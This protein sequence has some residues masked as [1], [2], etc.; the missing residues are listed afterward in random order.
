MPAIQRFM[1]IVDGYFLSAFEEQIVAQGKQNDVVVLTGYNTG[2]VG[3]SMLGPQEPLT[4]QS[5]AKQAREQYGDMAVEFLKLYPAATDQ[6][7]EIAKAQS[8]RDR[9]LTSM[10]L[11]A[12]SRAK[13]SKTKTFLYLWDHALPGPDSQKYGAFH[14]AE[15]PYVMNTL[16]YMPNRPFTEA[17]FKLADMM[18]SYWV[19]FIATGDPNGKGLSSWPAV[20]EKREIMEVGDVNQPV[21]AAGSSAKFIFFEKYFFHDR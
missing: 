10:Y 21:P 7:A 15:V 5:Y 20:G 1:P 18:S 12:K 9:F 3:S 13:T 6:E 11:W 2:E 16:L 8:D 14:T 19:N 4:A 17:D